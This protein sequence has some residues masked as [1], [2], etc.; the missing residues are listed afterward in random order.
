MK[1]IILDILKTILSNDG[2]LVSGNKLISTE[3]SLLSIK[4][5]DLIKVYN[6]NLN[7][8][9]WH[10]YESV[11]RHHGSTVNDDFFRNQMI[12]K[13]YNLCNK[14]YVLYDMEIEDELYFGDDFENQSDVDIL[15]IY[16]HNMF[17]HGY[18]KR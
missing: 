17:D 15:I 18:Y 6:Q 4:D 11:I 2:S 8:K 13:I 12:D 14:D 16:N 7:L 5:K 3:E 10:Q 9:G 1:S